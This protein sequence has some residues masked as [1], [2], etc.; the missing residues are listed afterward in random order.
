M[1]LRNLKVNPLY[2]SL[3]AD[4]CNDVDLQELRGRFRG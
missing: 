2:K 1:T 4:K 3:L